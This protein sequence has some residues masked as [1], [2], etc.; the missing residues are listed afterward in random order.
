M[1]V[2]ARG[3][4]VATVRAS[5]IAMGRTTRIEHFYDNVNVLFAM[6]S[7]GSARISVI[8]SISAGV[9]TEPRLCFL[10]TGGLWRRKDSS[11][12]G[13]CTADS[14]EGYV[15][16]RRRCAM[17]HSVCIPIGLGAACVLFSFCAS[18]RASLIQSNTSNGAV[19]YDWVEVGF[20]GHNSGA[21]D[22]ATDSSKL[23]VLPS[24]GPFTRFTCAEQARQPHT[25][26]NIY[27]ISH[28]IS[29]TYYA[30]DAVTKVNKVPWDEITLSVSG[31]AG[32]H[33]AYNRDG[34][35]CDAQIRAVSSFRFAV[36]IPLTDVLGREYPK[37][38]VGR[39]YVSAM[40]KPDMYSTYIAMTVFED[41]VPVKWKRAGGSATQVPLMYNHTYEL[42]LLYEGSVHFQDCNG[43]HP[44]YVPEADPHKMLYGVTAAIEP[45]LAKVPEPAGGI[46][47]LAGVAVVLALCRR[48][49]AAGSLR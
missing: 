46:L 10:W 4:V 13:A 30:L 19:L 26:T 15:G 39:L 6:N 22:L 18:A 47:A 21:G 29:R 31:T 32:A 45:A 11:G 35:P 28:G 34:E 44:D 27:D 7:S 25:T 33:D 36:D 1:V 2:L 5:V 8:L 12:A 38:P 17:S 9:R 3:R 41:G 14:C 42:R 43:L 16:S 49:H 23:H 20:L 48:R 37:L 24:P 40:P